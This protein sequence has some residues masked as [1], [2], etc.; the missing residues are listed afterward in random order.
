MDNRF[1]SIIEY[2]RISVAWTKNSFCVKEREE[3]IK[4]CG[5]LFKEFVKAIARKYDC[6]YVYLWIVYCL[7]RWLLVLLEDETA[8]N[9][10]KLS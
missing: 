8:S 3:K 9:L 10:S 1:F 2:K 7:K 6:F 4:K 5:G